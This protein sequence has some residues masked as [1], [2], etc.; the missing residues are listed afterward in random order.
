MKFTRNKGMSLAAVAIVLAV[1]NIITFVLPFNR[2]GSYWIGYGFT[3]LAILLT[4]GVGL[5]ALGREG[6]KSK[7]YGMSIVLVAWTY[8]IVQAIAGVLEMVIFTIPYQYTLV[9]NIVMLGA[10]LIG[11]IGVNMGKEEIER[12][13][14]KVNEKVFFIKSLQGDV[15]GLASRAS[16]GSLIKAL[17]ELADTIRYSDPM[18]SPL[19][20]TIEN[21]IEIKTATLAEAVE[22][23]DAVS[24]KGSIDEL[25]QL[26]AERNRKCKSLKQ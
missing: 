2:S 8:L 6:L 24:A 25:Q 9:I 26:F 7:F 14:A 3:M 13:E 1:F 21:K 17:K 4:A 12:I 23:D 11:L 15:E 19:L 10:C 18:S 20:A 16:D 5:Y 22:A